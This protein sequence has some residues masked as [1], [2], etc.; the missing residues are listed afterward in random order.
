MNSFAVLLTLANIFVVFG[1][2][3]VN[4]DQ[5]TVND[6]DNCGQGDCFCNEVDECEN[7]FSG[8]QGREETTSTTV[9]TTTTT[10]SGG[11]TSTAFETTS[12]TTTTTTV[13]TSSDGVW[14]E[15]TG[16]IGFLDTAARELLT[17][18]FAES[19]KTEKKYTKNLRRLQSVDIEPKRR[20]EHKSCVRTDELPASI[21]GKIADLIDL[22]D[23]R[24]SFKRTC[25]TMKDVIKFMFEMCRKKELKMKKKYKNI[26]KPC[27]KIDS[28]LKKL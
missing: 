18:T 3:C 15:I 20:Q 5:C 17:A 10:D 13:D 28:M 12:A 7:I 21:T 24:G 23:V 1:A 9:Q 2:K 6:P 22:E 27:Q 14:Q 4:D 26:E 11:G 25:A 16:P 8:Q 19:P